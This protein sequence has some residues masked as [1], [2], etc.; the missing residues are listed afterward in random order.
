[1]EKLLKQSENTS[2]R[3]VFMS[4][5]QTL[6][7]TINLYPILNNHNETIE[8]QNF[9]K[10]IDKISTQKGIVVLSAHTSNWDLLAAYSVYR[11]ISLVAFGRKARTPI[12]QYLL[13]YLR[14]KYSIETIWRDDKLALKKTILALK[15]GKVVAA[16]LDQDTRVTSEHIP[17]FDLPAKTPSSVIKIAKKLDVPIFSAFIF[18]DSLF[19]YKIFFEEIDGDLS[20]E[21]V[22]IEYNKRLERLV[23]KYP[24][25]WVWI[26]KR[27]RTRPENEALRTNDYIKFLKNYNTAA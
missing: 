25:Q 17:F 13:D 14:T 10:L 19:R 23:R 5:G 24:D 15:E 7:E 9:D 11:K 20:I 8:L 3:R 26:H 27:W 22:L 12:T 1:M 21:E 2:F 18:R 16:L 4:L 6:F